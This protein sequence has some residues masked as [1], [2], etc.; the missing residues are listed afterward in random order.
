MIEEEPRVDTNILSEK[1]LWS[2]ADMANYS[3]EQGVA[4]ASA[5]K[6]YLDEFWPGIPRKA[7]M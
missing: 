3:V 7:N 2:V 6:T 1:N 4:G 5:V